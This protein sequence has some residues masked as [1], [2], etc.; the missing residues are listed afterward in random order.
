MGG[1]WRR[2]APFK[3]RLKKKKIF[4]IRGARKS[5]HILLRREGGVG[6]ADLIFWN[7]EPDGGETHLSLHSRVGVGVCVEG[8][9]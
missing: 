8:Q 1:A 4:S 5:G 9:I 7:R 6:R 2:G 3:E